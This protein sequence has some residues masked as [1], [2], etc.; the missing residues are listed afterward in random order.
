MVW[1]FKVLF[2][3]I[4]VLSSQCSCV[5]HVECRKINGC[6]CVLPNDVRIDMTRL[7]DET[8]W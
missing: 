5:E 7:N 1:G 2:A 4:C 6:K 8:K 3:S